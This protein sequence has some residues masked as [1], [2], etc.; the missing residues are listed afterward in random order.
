[1]IENLRNMDTSKLLAR[2]CQEHF[3]MRIHI[4]LG[5]KKS[6]GK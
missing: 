2:L 4:M 1:M 3:C 6:I 5:E